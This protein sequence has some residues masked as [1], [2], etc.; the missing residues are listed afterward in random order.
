MDFNV[1][2]PIR[3]VPLL[4]LFIQHQKKVN[5]TG[6]KL[7]MVNKEFVVLSQNVV[8]VKNVTNQKKN[9]LLL[10]Y[11]EHV[12]MKHHVNGQL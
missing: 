9:V 11:L 6:K 8:M 10:V 3:N 2:Y 5:V 4:V 1:K 7:K 12:I